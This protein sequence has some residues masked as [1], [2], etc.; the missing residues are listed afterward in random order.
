MAD[1]VAVAQAFVQHFNSLFD[2]ADRTALAP[3]YVRSLL[4]LRL[5]ASASAALCRADHLATDRPAPPPPSS[6]SGSLP[7]SLPLLPCA[8][9]HSRSVGV[10]PIS[11]AADRP[12]RRRRPAQQE[13]SMLTYEG[14]QIQGQAA[15]INHYANPA[16]PA[17]RRRGRAAPPRPPAADTA[18]R[19]AAGGRGRDRPLPDAVAGDHRRRPT[20]PPVLRADGLHHRQKD[21]AAQPARPPP[22]HPA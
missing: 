8:A 16:S 17:A 10:P 6:G 18:P 13:S 2:S 21:G 1:P 20:H 5:S 15:I 11:I 9:P 4:R 14:T 22:A 19:A 12:R 7:L 3:L